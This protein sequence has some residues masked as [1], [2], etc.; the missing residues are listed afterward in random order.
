MW[1]THVDCEKTIKQVWESVGDLDP[2]VGLDK[3]IKQ[4]TWVLQRWSKS[5]FGHIKEE[6]RVLRAKFASLF[7][8]PYSERVEE[9]RRVV[10]KSLDELL[11]KNELYWSQRSREHWLKAGDKNTSYFHQKAT[12]RRRRNIIKGLEDS[13]GCWRTSRRGIT[14]IVTDYFGDLFRSSGPSRM[15]EILSALEPKVTADM[16]QVLIADFSYQEIK[17]AVFQMQPSKAPGPDGLPP[18]FYQKYWRI[19]GD[20]VVAAIRAFLQS[21]DMLRQLNH[22]FVTLIPKVKEPRT[23]AQL[24]PISLCNVLYRIGAKTLAN[25][26]K[27]V[28]QSVISESQSAFVPGRLITD[29]SIVAFEI[30]HFLKQR[31]RGRKGSLALKLDMSKA[32]DRVEWEFLEKMMLAMGFPIPWVRMVMDCVTTVSYSFLVNGEPTRILYPTRG[33]RQGD[34]LSPYLFLLC[35]EGFTTLLSKAERQG[36]LQGIVICRGAPTVSHLFFADDSFVF[37][38]ATD[39]N[40]GVL[41]HIFE[42]YERASGQQINC[43]KSCVAFSTNIHMDTQSRLASVLGVPR[44]DSHATYLGLPMML[45]RNKTFCFRYL[46]ERVWKKLQGLR[47]QTLSIAGK[48]V[49]LKVVAQSIP[50]YV[51]S[52]FLLPQGLCHEIEQMMARFWWGQQ[53]KNMKIHWM[54]WERLCKA[55]TECGMGFRCLQA[56]NMA[57]LAKQGWRLVHNP[58]SLA[59]RLLKAKYFPQTNFWEAMLGSRPSCV[60]KSIWTAR[61]VL[62]MGSRFQ[63]GDG[64]SVRI[65]G[66]KWVPRPATFAVITSPLDG[67]ENTKV[68]E[69]ICNEG[70][71]QW[72]LQKLNDLFLP[73]D[74]VDIVRIPL[75]FRAPPDRIVWNYDKHGLFTVKSAYRVALRVTSGDEDESSSSNSDTS[76][77]WR[78]I[79]NA[80]V[81]TKLKIFAWRVAHDILPTKAN[82][83]KKGVD[84]QDMCM[85][86]GDITESALHVLAMCPFA[87]ATWNIFLLTRHAHQGV[88]RSPH[89]VVGFAQQYV[90]EFS[91]A[92]DTPSKVTDR[93]RDPVRWAAPPSGRLKFNFDGAFDPTSGRGAVGVV[94]RDADG[95]FVAAVAKSVGEVLSAEHAEILAAREGVALALSLGTAS[96]IFEGDSAVVVS[97]VKRAGQDYSNIG[98]I[99]EDVKHLQ[100]QLPSSLFQFTHR[101]ANGVAHRLARFGLHNVDNFIWFEVPPDLIQ[102]ALLCDVLSR[103]QAHC[104]P[105]CHSSL[106]E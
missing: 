92:N 93:V 100:Q 98:T 101:E 7:Q 57:M 58:H 45:G 14:S 86:C 64:K 51:M 33:L 43:Q 82:L 94:A 24:H 19:V 52:C 9:D 23:M 103:G 46:K 67:M 65:W 44:V 32:Y 85:F 97:A 29:N 15:E 20:D 28:M 2:M 63:I 56:F 39:N 71:P 48:E 102:D 30:A 31:R 47:E 42:V 54:R 61:K 77:L 90:H 35:A 62:E 26:M 105:R 66:D 21:N 88:Q 74:V 49:L 78:H 5:T 59:S 41:K 18:L 55:K 13:N 37:A 17:D 3:K 10:Q 12:N 16:Q 68:S 81:P 75:S 80:N 36:Q 53:G 4:M 8:A 60:W 1:T 70:S 50:L 34:P 25:R 83:I 76:M 79:W 106:Y 38:K 89:D 27:F 11:A 69:L 104:P 84:M 87:V 72:D 22:T 73:V 99:V 96:P 95:G 6:T 40:C 91:T